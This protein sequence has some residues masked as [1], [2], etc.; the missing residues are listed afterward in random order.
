MRITLLFGIDLI[1]FME[2]VKYGR[3]GFVYK[4]HKRR[5]LSTGT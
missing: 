5:K 3:D 2:G 1:N 4:K